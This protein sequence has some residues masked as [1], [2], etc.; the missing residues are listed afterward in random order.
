MERI[1]VGKNRW[2]EVI[3][4]KSI[5]LYE[6]R[7]D[8]Y[9]GV[10]MFIETKFA[11]GDFAEYDSFNLSYTAPIKSITGKNVIFDLSRDRGGKKTTRLPFSSFHMRNIG[12]SL[13]ETQ[14]RNHETMMYI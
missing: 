12:F 11:I 5:T 4:G 2:A 14:R 3:P 8:R 7:K 6:V 9:D 13:E 10:E 1:E